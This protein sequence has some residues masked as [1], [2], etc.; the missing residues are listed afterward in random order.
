MLATDDYNYNDDNNDPTVPQR[1]PN[2]YTRH[3]V[4]SAYITCSIVQPSIHGGDHRLVPV[5]KEILV[6]PEENSHSFYFRPAILEYY[7]IVPLVFSTVTF[8]IRNMDDDKL[9][10]FADPMSPVVI[11]CLFRKR[12]LD[13]K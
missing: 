5:F 1:P 4:F 10:R 8:E 6:R 3:E 9:I 13:D 7:D 11:S 12:Q 2:V